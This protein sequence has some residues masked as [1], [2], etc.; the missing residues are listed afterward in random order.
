[1][2]LH[3]KFLESITLV[4]IATE[5]E[6]N[7]VTDKVPFYSE[8]LNELE[9]NIMEFAEK[10]SAEKEMLCR[11]SDR[12]R[13]LKSLNKHLKTQLLTKVK[14]GK[15]IESHKLDISEDLKIKENIEELNTKLNQER[16][17]FE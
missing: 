8:K 16:M 7:E 15:D 12:I 13:S 11:A 10:K 14:K 6:I 4:E 17:G 5:E 2:I 3:A 9:D 1:M